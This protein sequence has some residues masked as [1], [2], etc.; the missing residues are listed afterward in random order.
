MT[1]RNLVAAK[2]ATRVLR[3]LLLGQQPSGL[4]F[5]STQILF[6]S[7]PGKP[8]GEPYIN[9]ASA[10]CVFPTKPSSLPDKESDVRSPA[11]DEEEYQ[12]IISLR[13]KTV[14]DVEVCHP[15]PHLLVTF[16]EAALEEYLAHVPPN[17]AMKERHV[18]EIRKRLSEAVRTFKRASGG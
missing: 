2:E 4:R 10:W 3:H 15:A 1:N 12:L 16:D 9:L 6:Q 17:I 7:G 5:G 18:F 14:Q 8:E 11:S 13:H